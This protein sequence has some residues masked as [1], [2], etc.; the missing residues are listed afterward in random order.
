MPRV[1]FTQDFDYVP[2]HT[3]GRV[4]ISYTAGKEY[5]VKQECV[6][7]AGDLAVSMRRKTVVAA[8]E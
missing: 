2:S 5:S 4:T 6:E 8:D 7:Q 1:K 3:K